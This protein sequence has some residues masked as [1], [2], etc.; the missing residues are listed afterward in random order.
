MKNIKNIIA[1]LFVAVMGSSCVDE[2][3]VNQER[4]GPVVEPSLNVVV[5]NQQG[6]PVSGATVDFFASAA[7]YA[8]EQNVVSSGETNAE[9]VVT[10][11]PGDVGSERGD[12]FFSASSG[13]LRNWSS[14]VSSGY[15]YWSAGETVI[16][17][18]LAP[19]LPEF[20]AV[21]GNYT[22]TSYTYPGF[23]D[24][25]DQLVTAPCELDDIF[26]FRKDGLLIRAESSDVCAEPSEF[27]AP[28]SVEGA[29]WSTWSL[30]EDGSAMTIRDLDP[31][32]DYASNPEA[33]L[34]V[35]ANTV[36]IDY[37]SGYVATLTRI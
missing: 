1:I 21:L 28:V 11:S 3:T 36:T 9:G 33:G 6:E 12:Y 17:T 24:V 27:Q 10:L 37:G 18:T 2:D 26:T 25:Y 35:T 22:V 13:S 19:V 31:S 34:E 20:L 16:E 15:I 23:G 7:D 14:T 32:F 5:L 29:T 8:L 30:N 4:P